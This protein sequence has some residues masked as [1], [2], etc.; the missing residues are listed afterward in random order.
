MDWKHQQT[1]FH[2]PRFGHNASLSF[3][4]LLQFD[5]ACLSTSSL[6]RI[7]E[8]TSMTRVIYLSICE[9]NR[10][11]LPMRDFN[12]RP[13]L[14]GC[15]CFDVNHEPQTH[16]ESSRLT[17]VSKRAAHSICSWIGCPFLFECLLVGLVSHT[18]TDKINSTRRLQ[19]TT[20]K[21]RSPT[22]SF[23]RPISCYIVDGHSKPDDE[24]G[25]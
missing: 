15:L 3:G 19:L 20:N 10:F 12:A 9:R 6:S 2:V 5:N 24:V 14:S 4:Y 21:K 18:R 25:Q 23:S 17:A 11:V 16:I 1:F 7:F 8:L 13:H 22:F